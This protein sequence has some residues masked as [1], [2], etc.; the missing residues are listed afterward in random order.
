[1]HRPTVPQPVAAGWK[2]VPRT[3]LGN[4]FAMDGDR[5]DR[6][7]RFLAS[8]VRQAPTHN[9]NNYWLEHRLNLAF[10]PDQGGLWI[11]NDPNLDVRIIPRDRELSAQLPA[12]PRAVVRGLEGIT[13]IM[14]RALARLHRLTALQRL[15]QRIALGDSGGPLADPLG[16]L[17]AAWPERTHL[18]LHAA[19]LIERFAPARHPWDVLEIGSGPSIL[20]A[21]LR[22]RFGSRHVNVDLPEQI[23]VGF[24]L[25][26]EFLPQARILLPHEL[27]AQPGADFDVVFVTP[28]QLPWVAQRR[29]DVAANMFSFGEMSAATVEEYFSLLRCVLQPDGVFYCANRVSKHSP[30]DGAT[31]AFASYPWRTGDAVL[32]DR[33]D[34]SAVP[35]GSRGHR[36]RVVRLEPSLAAEG[37]HA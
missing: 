22:T 37:V 18:M 10:T 6:L 14:D 28:E 31:S 8:P 24:S 19:G 30:N 21:V 35:G 9:I 15:R 23:A 29:F 20:T 1:M 5:V 32:H 3:T 27:E 11:Y 34:L 36:E 33:T 26:S 2:G 13:R 12:L 17:R 16:Q 4:R 25:L 7:R